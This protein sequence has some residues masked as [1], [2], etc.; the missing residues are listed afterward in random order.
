VLG[1][2]AL[3]ARAT[4]SEQPPRPLPRPQLLL[5][6]GG[7]FLFE[8]PT[9]EAF[10]RPPALAAGFRL[11][12]VRYPL[13]DLRGAVLAARAEARR[14]RHRYGVDRVYA[15]GTSA[16]GTLAALL[17]GDGLVSAAVAKAPVADLLGWEWPLGAYG[18]DYW[19]RLGAGPA[20][21]RRLSPLRRP[22]AR[23]LLVV[24]GRADRV[25]PAGMNEAYAAKFTRVRLWVVAGGHR[26][27]RARPRLLARAMR[28]LGRIAARRAREASS[29]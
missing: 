11:H 3:P 12:Y 21:R 26:T 2:L 23:P 27:E 8:D 1:A 7:S 9:F 15:Y 5:F 24:Q 25:V 4:A 16:G 22:A 17:S 10:T 14:L 18:P 6:H 19:E 13:G 29:S 20:T 28:W